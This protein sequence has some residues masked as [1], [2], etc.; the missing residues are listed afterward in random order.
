MEPFIELKPDPEPELDPEIDPDPDP[1]QW[2]KQRGN[3]I[4]ST[5]PLMLDV[6]PHILAQ[7]L[8]IPQSGGRAY[9]HIHQKGHRSDPGGAKPFIT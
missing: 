8:Q 4:G 1:P 2:W 9:L 7:Q 5:S 6:W 3:E